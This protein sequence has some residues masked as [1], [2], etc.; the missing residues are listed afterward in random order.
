MKWL[1][2]GLLLALLVVGAVVVVYQHYT[3]PYR[4]AEGKIFGTYYN[5]TYQSSE[6]LS[7]RIVE[8]LN[9]VDASLSMF[10]SESTL[11]K[12][13][14]NESKELDGPCLYLLPRAKQIA[15]QTLGAFD[16]TVAPLVN[17]W[18]FGTGKRKEELAQD[19]VE[20]AVVEQLDS[21]RSFVGID[22]ISVEGKRIVKSDPRTQIDLSAIAKGYGVDVVANALEK[23]KV[24]NYMIE[25]GGEVRTKGK[26][27]QGNAWRIG[28]AKPDQEET[29]YQRILQLNDCAL[30]TSGNYRNFFYKDGVR[31]AHT[32]DPRTGHPVQQDILSVTVVAPQCYE[33]DAFATAFMVLGLEKTKEVLAQQPHLKAYII[34]LDE[35]G[36]QQEWTNE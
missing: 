20:L 18:G 14:R 17:A 1:W 35:N 23:E 30:A 9:G 7:A 4:H 34:Y 6:D 8:A 22:K 15:E 19:S 29:G 11:A 33:A 28:V 16:P 36:E 21:L 10:N 24:G 32:I 5:I 13:N 27:A 2:K 3:A 31:Y 26:N 25:I 12:I